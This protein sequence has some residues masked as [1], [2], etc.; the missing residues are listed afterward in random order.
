MTPVE[1]FLRSTDA[2][3][4]GLG[5]APAPVPRWRGLAPKLAL[6]ALVLLFPL[7][8]TPQFWIVQANYIGL[9]AMA[10]IGLVLLTGIG[11]M[12]SFGQAA[13]VGIGAYCTAYLST[14]HGVSPWLTL[15]IGL[16][17]TGVSAWLL[18]AITLRMSGHYLPLATIAWGISLYL[19]F[20]KLS[21]LGSYDGISGVPAL[22]A[23]GVDLGN[24]RGMYYLI[25]GALLLAAWVT[26]N[27]LDSRSGRAIRALKGGKVMAEAM[28]VDTARHKILVFVLAA[29]LAAVSGWLFAHMQRTV[30]P[31]PFS[32]KMGI[33]YLFMAV[34]GGAAHVWGAVLGAGILKLL[35]DQLQVLLPRIFGDSGSYEGIVLGLVLV[36]MLK[37]ARDGLWP[38]VAALA[39]RVLPAAPPRQ[40]PAAAAPLPR[41]AVPTAGG[42]LL[43]VDAVTKRFGGLVAVNAVSFGVKA[44]EIVGLIGP[45]GAGKST[46]FNLV[47]GLLKPTEGAVRFQ[48]EQIAGLN[49]RAIAKR[50]MARTFQHVKL[51]PS[52]T[53]LENVALGAHQRLGG[54]MGMDVAR[55]MLRLDRADEARLLAEAARALE[56]VGLAHLMHEQAGSLALGQ[57]RIMEIAR[58]LCCDPALLLL[59]EPAAGLRHLEKQALADVLKQLRAG[60]MSILLVEHDMEFVMQLTD[61]IVVMEFGTKIAEGTP[62]QIQ[63][64]P[65]VIEAYLGGVE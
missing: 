57:Q 18:G 36:L 12:T 19:L 58:A 52:M 55:A 7:L 54:L 9:Y 49:S 63:V 17:I 56:Q 51:L 34:V 38:R 45:N 28:G 53:V 33:E 11:G 41:R 32:I 2:A 40:A 24:D 15:W 8:P 4:P 25:W 62:E 65:A 13:F 44:G 64:H 3:A 20:G 26:L 22:K 10:A 30:N 35:E 23:F 6:L 16:A 39:A 42:P 37:Y 46:T 61:H 60:G 43:Q 48:G 29:L 47:S 50:G 59:D 21:W 5:P 14:A 27:L 31:S 1:Q